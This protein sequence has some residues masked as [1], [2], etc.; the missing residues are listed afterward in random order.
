MKSHSDILYFCAEHN[1]VVL[2]SVVLAML[3]NFSSPSP[4]LRLAFF[5]VSLPI[6]VAWESYSSWLGKSLE[7]AL[8]SER[9]ELVRESRNKIGGEHCT[10]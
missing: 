6:V 3:S 9:D 2:S 10:V 1:Y 4:L 5:L 7:E 8:L